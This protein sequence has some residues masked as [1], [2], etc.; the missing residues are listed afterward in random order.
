MQLIVK[1]LRYWLDDYNILVWLQ[2]RKA[3]QI[4]PLTLQ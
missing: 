2:N 1:V 3:T 4:S